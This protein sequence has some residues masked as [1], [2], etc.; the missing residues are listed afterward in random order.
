MI[1]WHMPDRCAGGRVETPEERLVL[2]A[3]GATT[4]QGFMGNYRVNAESEIPRW[5]KDA[6]KSIT[7]YSDVMPLS[8]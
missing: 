2:N 6:R 3:L 8:D 7:A 5:F 4:F 1:S